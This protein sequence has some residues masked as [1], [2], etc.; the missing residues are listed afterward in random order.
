M[1]PWLLHCMLGHTAC[2][3]IPPSEHWTLRPLLTSDE[4]S[5]S[6][7]VLRCH[8]LQMKFLLL[9]WVRLCAWFSVTFLPVLGLNE[10][11]RKWTWE[12]DTWIWIPTLPA[13]WLQDSCEPLT[14]SKG[15]PRI[16]YP[17]A[18][19][20]SV[21]LNSA[22]P[23][24]NLHPWSF[25]AVFAFTYCINAVYSLPRIFSGCILFGDL[26]GR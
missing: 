11:A 9:A 22:R 26:L 4:N 12:T 8:R 18:G 6:V 21:P 2:V 25:S 1:Q 23:R 19:V 14:S 13:H 10:A 3:E 7:C 5:N 24:V 15:Y 20:G 16:L 17:R